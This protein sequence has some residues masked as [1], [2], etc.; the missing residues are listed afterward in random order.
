M[1]AAESVTPESPT[2]V[3]T[4]TPAQVQS[5]IV[6]SGQVD[7]RLQQN[8]STATYTVNIP[9]SP[10]RTLRASRI[11][12]IGADYVEVDAMEALTKEEM[13]QRFLE[14]V[15]SWYAPSWLVNELAICVSYAS[16]VE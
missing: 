9:G 3:R 5:P 7:N 6:V 16:T 12:S 4:T 10:N 13:E 15:V 14:I 11:Q 8:K 1:G 2:I